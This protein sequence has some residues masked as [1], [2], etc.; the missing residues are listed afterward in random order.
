MA[1]APKFR[2]EAG[3]S[4]WEISACGRKL[5]PDP[6]THCGHHDS[7]AH[8][9]PIA[10]GSTGTGKAFRIHVYTTLRNH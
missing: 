5:L 7:V 10:A 4:G 3:R 9:L 8:Q 2:I 6:D 1:T